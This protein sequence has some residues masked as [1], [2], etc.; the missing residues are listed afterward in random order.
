MLSK[1]QSYKLTFYGV[2]K[3]L[4]RLLPI[5]PSKIK[6]SKNLRLA[7]LYVQ[8]KDYK[9]AIRT[10]EELVYKFNKYEYYFMLLNLYVM[11]GEL[12]KANRL[13]EDKSLEFIDSDIVKSMDLLN[14]TVNDVDKVKFV[15][16]YVKSQGAT[17][18][19]IDV[20][21]LGQ[22]LKIKSVQE[23]DL[24]SNTQK[25]AGE[26]KLWGQ[27]V[28]VPEY[29]LSLYDDAE[30]SQIPTFFDYSRPVIK[31]TKVA[32][33]DTERPMMSVKNGLR[34]TVGQPNIP[35]RKVLF[36]GSSTTYSSGMSDIYTLVSQ[37]QRS[38][39]KHFS[40][41]VLENHGI[42]GMK[43]L[44]AMNNLVQTNIKENDIVVFFNFDEF[45]SEGLQD[46]N[47]IDLNLIERGSDFFIDLNDKQ[48]HYSP[49]GNK[50]LSEV[51]VKEH[52]LP[53]LKNED[54]KLVNQGDRIDESILSVLEKFKYFLF[55]HTAQALE[56]CEMQ[57]YLELLDQH[58][59]D[60]EGVIGSVAVNCN[61]ITKGHLHLIE[62]A[63]KSVD[64]LFIFV[65][66]EDKSFFKFEDRFKLVFES[67]KH[68]GNVTVIRGGKFICT[69]LT[70]PDYFD[71]ETSE[72][73]ADAS[74]EA[75]FFCE[76]IA[77]ALNIS[78]IFLGNEPKCQITQQYNEKMQELLPAYDIEVEIIE[79]ISTNGDVISASKVREFLASRDFSSIEAIV[80]KPTYQFLKE[81]Y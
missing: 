68:I 75:W 35:A 62:H 25:Y 60:N 33:L 45:R 15:T 40:D 58:A 74:M 17:P 54:S 67:T 16:D 22:D 3:S 48:G 71:K 6:M 44:Q 13:Q 70:Y 61:P 27:G 53:L 63:A 80:P 52:L 1:S 11:N 46:L 28:K 69:E 55:R 51:I 10:I 26:R 59:T 73:K 39:N 76:Y 34:V 72:A 47:K 24:M 18:L 23:K 2:L 9:N 43:L 12:S 81:N 66:E 50:V 36:F 20:V 56:S 65:I 7:E 5:L 4:Y 14:N 8:K 32:L 42:I 78:K 49:R 77:K 31:G 29:I 64:K 21:G 19:L 79:R 37:V 38:I 57:S 41:V 30:K